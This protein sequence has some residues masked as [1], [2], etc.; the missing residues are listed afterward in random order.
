MCFV[1]LVM[2][3]LH[4][5]QHST[6]FSSLTCEFDR[7]KCPYKAS[8]PYCQNT[9]SYL[10][11]FCITQCANPLRYNT[12]LLTGIKKVQK[13]YFDAFPPNIC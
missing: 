2:L 4:L 10:T 6:Y 3:L 12:M 8:A 13:C 11:L 7:E 9:V 1:I 5:L